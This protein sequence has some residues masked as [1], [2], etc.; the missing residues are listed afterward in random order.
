VYVRS[1]YISGLSDLPRL[2]AQ[3]LDRVVR[4]RGPGP[5]ATAMG[6]AVALAFAALSTPALIDLLQRWELLRPDEEPE[7]E[8]NPLPIQAT[9][10]DQTL[11]RGLV[12]DKVERKLQVDLELAVDPP[13]FA[14]L[15]ALG[16]RAPRLAIALGPDVP[17]RLQVS[18][19]FAASWDALSIA[20]QSFSVGEESFPTTG[21]ERPEWLTQLL[22]KIGGRFWRHDA[23]STAAISA[24][25]A[26]TSTR[27]DQ[28]AGFLAWQRALAP[29]LG[30]VRP[31]QGPAGRA[32]LLAD[33]QPI[34]RFGRFGYDRAAMAASVFFSGADL[35][36]AGVTDDWVERFVEGEGSPLEQIWRVD[37][38]GELDPESQGHDKPRSVLHFDAPPGEE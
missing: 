32:M 21:K 22:L 8:S 28:H 29:V 36:W 19:F 14:E 2:S 38:A 5:A 9:W 10:E 30:A 37:P 26:M 4:I 24:M 34:R 27:S 25:S 20:V 33:E 13:L 23:T 1:L 3:G 15:R 31:V 16:G 18:A 6:D 11:A 12:A 7:V 35:L 17:I